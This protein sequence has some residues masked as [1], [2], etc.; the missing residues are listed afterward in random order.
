MTD[1]N[2]ITAELQKPLDPA[3]IKP[4]PKGKFGEYVDGYHVIT[5]ANRIFGHDGWSYQITRLEQTSGQVYDLTGNNGPYQQYRCSYLCTVRV[6]AGGVTR[7]GAAVGMG[8]GK[9]ENTSDV[10]ESAVKE[11]ETDALKRALRS[12]GNTFG[13]ALYEK[14]KAK[15]QVGDANE[16]AEII[17]QI[18]A[19]KSGREL[20]EAV[21][22]ANGK[23]QLDSVAKARVETLRM[24]VKGAPSFD[25][26]N[27]LS[28]HFAPDWQLVKADADARAEEL[29]MNQQQK[30]A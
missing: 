23:N 14:D 21:K 22:A 17:G 7:E 3:A 10:I 19:A 6:T 12:F 28:K 15:R 18:E 24:I 25:A 2:R 27:A 29:T 1:W 16:V 20:L 30:V 5:E 11:A 4:P 13:L 8:N 9:P 26:L